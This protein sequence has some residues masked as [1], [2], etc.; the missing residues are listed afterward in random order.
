MKNLDRIG[1]LSRNDLRQMKDLPEF[2]R[3]PEEFKQAENFD[4]HPESGWFFAIDS[5]SD[6]FYYGEYQDTDTAELLSFHFSNPDVVNRIPVFIYNMECEMPGY[7]Y[8]YV[9]DYALF[10]GM[11]FYIITDFEGLRV[12]NQTLDIVFDLRR[13]PEMKT[14]VH[15]FGFSVDAETRQ[16]VS[17]ICKEKQLDPESGRMK[18]NY[19]NVSLVPETERIYHNVFLV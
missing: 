16:L 11:I 10:D 6:L 19:D 18:Y 8:W 17:W 15:A 1:F 7:D 4:Y 3:T 13:T 2:Q 12:Y 5:K 14:L 9:D